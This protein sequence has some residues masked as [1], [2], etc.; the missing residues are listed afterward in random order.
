MDWSLFFSFFF[1]MWLICSSIGSV[2]TA[3][4]M[5]EES[6]RINDTPSVKIKMITLFVIGAFVLG[7]FW[8]GAL[9]YSQLT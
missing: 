3:L 5:I 1:T 2:W 6:K 4:V 7:P 8:L 9:L